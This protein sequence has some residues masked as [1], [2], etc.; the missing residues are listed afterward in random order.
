[1]IKDL[2]ELFN[3]RDKAF[4]DATSD[5][6]KQIDFVYEA[7]IAFLDENPHNIIWDS[8][9]IN[10]SKMVVIVARIVDGLATS[11]LNT[12]TLPTARL[13]TIGI[14]F[15]II[16]TGTKDGVIKFLA[17]ME[18]A[19]IFNPPKKSLNRTLSELVADVESGHDLDVLLAD[20]ETVSQALL[21]MIRGETE[22]SSDDEFKKLP[23][24]SYKKRTIH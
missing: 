9:E 13:L 16:N 19:R 11:Q 1:M 23:T 20:N 18:I 6:T 3:K 15:N 21:D 17:D 5:I 12:D 22:D 2:V 14:P 8:I 10:A 24:S 4:S 7:I